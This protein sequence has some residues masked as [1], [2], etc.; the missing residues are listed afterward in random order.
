MGMLFPFQLKSHPSKYQIRGPSLLVFGSFFYI[1]KFLTSGTINEER[2]I[3]QLE[4]MVKSDPDL[5]AKLQKKQRDS[6]I[7]LK[8]SKHGA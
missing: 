6:E 1:C 8:E 5:L 7:G 4:R 2:Q 3:S